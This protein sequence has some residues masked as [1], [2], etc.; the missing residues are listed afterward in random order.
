MSTNP[1]ELPPVDS[2]TYEQ[3]LAE[4]EALVAAL[5]SEH[6]DLA[7]ALA[8]FE[9]GQALARRCIELL[10]QA[11]LKVQQ[12]TAEGFTDFPAQA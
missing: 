12:L 5:E 4:L 3:A 7:T 8:S 6:Q 2:L 10:D 9:R 1:P 11:E